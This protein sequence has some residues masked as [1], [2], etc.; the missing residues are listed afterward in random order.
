VAALSPETLQ[1][2]FDSIAADSM[3]RL[4]AKAARVTPAQLDADGY[5]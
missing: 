2:F 4:L 1:K 3:D 5:S